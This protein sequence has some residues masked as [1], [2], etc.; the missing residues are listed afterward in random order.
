[1]STLLIEMRVREEEVDRLRDAYRSHFRPAV[2]EQPGFE[3]VALLE[4]CEGARWVIVLGF[5]SEELRLRWVA[6]DAHQAAWPRI[7]AC[8]EA[9]EA[10]RCVEVR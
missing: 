8:C 4:P 9:F 3:S 7:V 6:T 2:M 5:A 1:M 10:T